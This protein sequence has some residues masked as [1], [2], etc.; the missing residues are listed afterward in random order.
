METITLNLSL[1]QLV[2]AICTTLA[3]IVGTVAGALW[4]LIR[5][6][7]ERAIADALERER[8]AWAAAV[9]AEREQRL[10]EIK[11]LESAEHTCRLDVIRQVDE[12]RS[13]GRSYRGEVREAI[14]AL[15][16]RIDRVLERLANGHRS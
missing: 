7:V 1:L 16:T 12:V 13:E 6:R 10:V 11:R 4:L 3:T 5:P 9:A 14:E 15:S 2:A 8:G